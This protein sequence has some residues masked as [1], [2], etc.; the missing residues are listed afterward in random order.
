MP[1]YS[2]CVSLSISHP[3]VDTNEI[4]EKLNVTPSIVR[5]IG[6]PRLSYSGKLL[7][8]VNKESF[9]RL[10]LHDEKRLHSSQVLMEDFIAKQNER[11]QSNKEYFEELYRSGGY[12]EYFIGWFSEGSINMSVR[13]EPDLLKSTAELYISIGLDAYPE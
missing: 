3:T 13:F 6:E 8:G 1:D 11:F 5:N 12:I 4:S 2:Y 9:W 10:G 7:G